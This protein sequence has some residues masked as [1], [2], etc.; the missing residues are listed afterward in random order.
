M[1]GEGEKTADAARYAPTGGRAVVRPH[2]GHGQGMP[3]PYIPSRS[4]AQTPRNK[5]RGEPYGTFTDMVCPWGAEGTMHRAPT[6]PGRRGVEGNET[7][8]RLMADARPCGPTAWRGGRRFANHP[9]TVGHGGAAADRG[10]G[11]ANVGDYLPITI[12]Q[13]P[14]VLARPVMP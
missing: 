1:D 3:C 7:R 9:D 11:N 2:K 10:P 6:P 8:I 12:C 13:S 14:T 4:G 5:R